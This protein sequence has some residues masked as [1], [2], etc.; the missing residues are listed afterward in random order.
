MIDWQFL[1]FKEDSSYQ[2]TSE[3][4]CG[5]LS[6]L[7]LYKLGAAGAPT[8][9][10]NDSK[11]ALSWTERGGSVRSDIAVRAGLVFCQFVA[12]HQADVVKT[13]WLNHDKNSRT[14]NLSRPGGSWA[15][16][17]I[18]DKTKYGGKLPHS[19]PFLELQCTPLIELCNPKLPLDTEEQFLKFFQGVQAFFTPLA[20]PFA[21]A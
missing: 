21:R 5:V 14:D 1:D 12:T 2:N 9:F 8:W 17:L 19:L 13:T 10:R 16:V 20:T 7:G 11:T 15:A 3:Y 6:L 4:L 18:D